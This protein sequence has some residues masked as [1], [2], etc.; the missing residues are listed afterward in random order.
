MSKSFHIVMLFDIAFLI[1]LSFCALI[2]G[3]ALGSAANGIA[4]AFVTL[5]YISSFKVDKHA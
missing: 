5:L 2:D 1:L 3:D 4:G